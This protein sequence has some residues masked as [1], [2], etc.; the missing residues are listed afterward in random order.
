MEMNICASVNKKYVRYLYVMLV[1]LFE[2]NPDDSITVYIM[3]RDLTEENHILLRNLANKYDNSVCF[4]SVNEGAYKKFHTTEQYSM[5]T[6]FRLDI[7]QLVPNY[8]KKI[9]YLDVDIIVQGS[10]R[11]LFSMSMDEM[12][13]MACQD[14]AAVELPALERN[15]FGR[16]DDLRYFNAGV[17]MWNLEKLREDDIGFDNYL[18]IAEELNYNLPIVD[19]D[20]LNYGYYDKTKYIDAKIY[21]YMTNV[22]LRE[23]WSEDKTKDAVILHFSGYNPWKAGPKAGVT[24]IWWNYAKKTPFYQ[25]M[26]E[27]QVE[28]LEKHIYEKERWGLSKLPKGQMFEFNQNILVKCIITSTFPYRKPHEAVCLYGAG[29]MAS[30]FYCA[31]KA[32]KN[33]EFEITAVI[34]RNP[35][36]VFYDFPVYNDTTWM[37]PMK[38]YLLI[39]TP[40]DNSEEIRASLIA[41]RGEKD[42]I[43]TMQEFLSEY[44]L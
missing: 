30:L 15:L 7:A 22:F 32:D 43:M 23:D 17:M 6:Y 4:L 36:S 18:R 16:Y 20:I 5:E 3:N 33:R 35:D 31:L 42:R 13:F 19:Q 12:Y 44:R 39:I 2:N 28:C 21:N 9:L 37:E 27:E 25:E 41:E 40:V 11:E 14:I 34:D 29:K 26:L 24:K 1:S 38:G 8:V 10:L